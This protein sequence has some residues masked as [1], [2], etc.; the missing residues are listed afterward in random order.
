MFCGKLCSRRRNQFDFE[1]YLNWTSMV[2][3]SEKTLRM[4]DIMLTE[5]NNRCRFTRLSQQ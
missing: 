5:N 2:L 1:C 4:T 3:G